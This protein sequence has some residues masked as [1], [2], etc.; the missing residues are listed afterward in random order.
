MQFSDPWWPE[1]L[2]G[3]DYLHIHNANMKCRAQVPGTQSFPM[4]R[5]ILKWSRYILP[6]HKNGKPD[7][8]MVLMKST[9]HTNIWLVICIYYFKNRYS[10]RKR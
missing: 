2:G 3:V 7:V 6:E 9:E 10:I 5:S 4:P 8:L 1:T